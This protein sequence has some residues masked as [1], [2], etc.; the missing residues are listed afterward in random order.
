MS[1]ELED[2]SVLLILQR[3]QYPRVDILAKKRRSDRIIPRDCEKLCCSS[4][5]LKGLY[6][7]VKKYIVDFLETY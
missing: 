4:G 2:F 3:L 6:F 7:I 1:P 5:D